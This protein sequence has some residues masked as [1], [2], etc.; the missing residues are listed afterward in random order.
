MK[1]MMLQSICLTFAVF[2][3]FEG[4]CQQKHEAGKK[5]INGKLYMP[6]DIVFNLK[7]QPVGNSFDITFGAA[8]T[9]PDSSTLHIPGFYNGDN[10]YVIRF[11]PTQT[12]QWSYQTFSSVPQLSGTAGTLFVEANTNPEVHGAV[13]V[14]PQHP[15]KFIY[16]DG[17]PYFAL[18]FELNWL[19]ALDYEKAIKLTLS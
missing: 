9:A 11:S 2:L 4:F 14:S 12:G 19:F 18:A 8:F 13:T 5:Q 10:E 16:E 7:Q 3:T 15:Q 1:K 6:V 17:T